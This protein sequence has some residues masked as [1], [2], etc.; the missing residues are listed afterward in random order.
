MRLT[1]MGL[2]PFLALAFCALPPTVQA[3][4]DDV[5]KPDSIERNT[6]TYATADGHPLQLDLRI[7]HPA[8]QDVPG[9][10]FLH[11][12]GF[13][14]GQRNRGPHVSL[15][16]SLAAHGIPSASISYRLT[17]KG[18]GF[19]CSIPAEEKQG[20][21]EAAVQDLMAAH[22]WLESSSLPLP[23]QWMVMGSSAGAEAAMWAG[24]G[25]SPSPFVG[26]VSFAGAISSA[27]PIPHNPAPFFGVHGQCDP[28]VPCGEALHRRCQASDPGAWPLCGSQCWAERMIQS[29][30]A[31]VFMGFCSGDHSVCNSGMTSPQIQ[32]LLISW[33]R[34]AEGKQMSSIRVLD[35]EASLQVTPGPCPWPCQ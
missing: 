15:L 23:G 30:H 4:G 13:S 19:G 17:M 16:D 3:D 18:K 25:L 24:Y 26:V 6:W 32:D 21:V 9:I 29:G 14:S 10:I 35:G 22:D 11:G 12:G 31:A 34:T 28:V 2:L 33:L 8:E 1:A 7:P 27:V 20:A 5:F